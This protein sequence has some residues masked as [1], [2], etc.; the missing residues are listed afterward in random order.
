MLECTSE[1]HV[2][3]SPIGIFVFVNMFH[4]L[5][6]TRIGYTCGYGIVPF[7]GLCVGLRAWDPLLVDF[8]GHFDVDLGSLDESEAIA[9]VEAMLSSRTRC[10][11]RTLVNS[12]THVLGNA[13]GITLAII[14]ITASCSS[15]S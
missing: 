6:V 11:R 4:M 12:P 8:D 13:A 3:C 5:V 9:R 14:I 2:G 7:V 10:E 15:P 1:E